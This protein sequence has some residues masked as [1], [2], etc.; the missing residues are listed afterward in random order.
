MRIR[1]TI[2]DRN[3]WPYERVL[4]AIYPQSP[5]VG[6][7]TSRKKLCPGME[8]VT[9]QDD[10]VAS[11]FKPKRVLDIKID[12]QSGAKCPCE[13]VLIEVGKTQTLEPDGKGGIKVRTFQ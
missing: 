8:T 12:V 9:L 7:W 3:H 6:P 13:I 2:R 11:L 1:F 10:P 5:T 4:A